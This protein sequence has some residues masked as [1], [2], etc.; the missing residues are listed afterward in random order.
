MPQFSTAY[1]AA[2]TTDDVGWWLLSDAAAA[3]PDQSAPEDEVTLTRML[4]VAYGLVVAYVLGDLEAAGLP[5][6][7]T[8]VD[9]VTETIR[10][11][12]LLQARAQWA[13]ERTGG[14][15]MIGPDGTQIR[16]Y[17][18]GWQVKNLIRPDD[19]V[20]VIG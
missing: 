1:S 11:A 5:A 13:F 14:G 17:P 15:D 20:P 2:F 8:I 16:V 12:Q 6:D 19:G 3:W 18:M 10:E 4:K 7:W 9:P